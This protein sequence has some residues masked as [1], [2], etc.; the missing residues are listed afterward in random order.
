[1]H[2]TT[3]RLKHS[4]P[5][6]YRWWRG[7]KAGFR[8]ERRCERNDAVMKRLFYATLNGEIK[9]FYLK[10]K[11]DEKGWKPFRAYHRSPKQ[12]NTI[13][14]SAGWVIKGEL[15]PGYDVQMKDWDDFKREGYSTGIW[16]VII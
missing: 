7:G 2:L 3:F 5:Q 4:D 15:S 11:E 16:E 10:E 13:Q 8:H 6:E 12:D 1:M 14:L 9:G